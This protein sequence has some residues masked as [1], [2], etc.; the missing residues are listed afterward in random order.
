M[1]ICGNKQKDE[2]LSISSIFKDSIKNMKNTPNKSDFFYFTEKILNFRF[3]IKLYNDNEKSTR[4]ITKQ[5]GPNEKNIFKVIK[6]IDQIEGRELHYFSLNSLSFLSPESNN[7]HINNINKI[8][9]HNNLKNS[10]ENTNIKNISNNELRY[11]LIHSFKKL[12]RYKKQKVNKILL[13]GPPNNIRW[14]IWYSMAKNKYFEIENKIGIKNSNIFNYLI[15]SKLNPEI[16]KKIK[17]DLFNTL[18]NIK[19][20]KK[21]N[22]IKSLFNLLKAYSIYD[23]EI[24]YKNGMNNIA[25]NILIVSDC[26]EIESFQFLRFFYSNYYG[27]SFR[28]FFKENSSKLNFYS[29]L[30]LELIKERIYPIYEIISKFQIEN[31]LWLNKWII[32][33]FEVL[34]D[35]CVI[36]R[37][38]D[39]MISLGINFLINFTLGLL[40]YYQNNIIKFKDKSAFLNFFSRKIKFKNDKDILIYRERLI[41][42]SLDFNI[43]HETII[44]I[45]N[46]YN[47]EMKLKNTNNLIYE[48]EQNK[49]ENNNEVEMMKFIEK[50]INGSKVNFI[51]DDNTEKNNIKNNRF[52][53][54][55]YNYS[56]IFNNNNKYNEKKSFISDEEINTSKKKRILNENMLFNDNSNTIE[57]DNKFTL[58]QNEHFNF[59]IDKENNTY[60]NEIFDNNNN[61]NINKGM[62]L[63]DE[64]DENDSKKVNQFD[65]K[66]IEEE[67]LEEI[68]HKK[69]LK[70]EIE[71]SIKK[72]N[73]KN[74]NQIIKDEIKVNIIKLKDEKEKEESDEDSIIP[75]DTSSN[76]TINQ[77]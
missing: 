64:E 2:T 7:F 67:Q 53:N 42:L 43:S 54:K 69:M 45:L 37:L 66:E 63:K 59:D 20:F 3:Y 26:N 4:L 39:C 77:D 14:V 49:N 46:N 6:A 9:N 47:Q 21:P 22:W 11:S 16:E 76:N 23:K 72:I 35:F 24:G 29:F 30:I 60:R 36:I 55:N 10:S 31:D 13:I 38:Y 18:P 75:I 57:D 48:I 70:E 56:D 62:I 50:E 65:E 40:K 52:K 15:N 8:N 1:G 58:N 28:D 33:L 74:E 19:H 34:F 68:I 44:R 61:K 51:F 73:K 12:C 25:A 17:N 32:N 71:D 5:I 41:K 27:L